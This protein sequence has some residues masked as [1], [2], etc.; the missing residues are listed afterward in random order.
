M[1]S[2]HIVCCSALPAFS[3]PLF[4]FPLLLLLLFFFLFFFFCI[5][6]WRV[7]YTSAVPGNVLMFFFFTGVLAMQISCS[8]F[9]FT[10]MLA[11]QV[12][13]LALLLH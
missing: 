1:F 6:G 5:F 8:F 4:L 9:F 3:F 11:V 10:G 12:K 13:L 2:H 7:A